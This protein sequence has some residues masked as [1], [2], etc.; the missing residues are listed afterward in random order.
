ML[1]IPNP[2]SDLTEVVKI[3]CDIFPIL[4]TYK[5][6]D[7]D[8]VSTA[9]IKTSNVTSQGAIGIE[10][11]QR[12]TRADRSRDPIYNQ[13]KALCELYRLLGWLQSTTAQTKFIVTY[14]GEALVN[15]ENK[16]QIVEE[17][18]LGLTYPNECVEVK[19]DASLRPFKSILY[20]LNENSSITRDEIIYGVLNI[21]D[22]SDIKILNKLAKEMQTFR[23]TK[24]GLKNR[25]IEIG[26][27]LSIK[28]D[29]TM[30]NYTRFPI[31]A[32]KWAD[33]VEKKS[34]RLAATQG[35]LS[36]YKNLLSYQDLRLGDF[37]ALPPK[38]K[39]DLIIYSHLNMMERF[40]INNNSEQ[41]KQSFTRLRQNGI[42]KTNNI[43]F[44]PYQILS[45]DT[46]K[47]YAPD[48][49][50]K[51]ATKH[52]E[53]NLVDSKSISAVKEEIKLNF[54][55]DS[56]NRD[57]SYIKNLAIYK[58]ID[59]LLKQ[60]K[61][62]KQTIK[63]LYEKYS[64]VNKEI[65]YPL[66]ADLFCIIGFNC[67]VSRGGQNYERADAIIIDDK[68]SIPI[69][70][71][72]PGEETEISVKAV[73]QALEN[74]IIFL[75]RQQYKTD[76]ST[77]SLAVGYNL[78]NSRSEVF[79]LID[80]IYKTFKFNICILGFEDLLVLAISVITSGKEIKIENFRTL[81]GVYNVR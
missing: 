70:I 28:Y 51:D 31:A 37:N 17:C 81:R 62:E 23:K 24:D 25:L 57:V 60:T 36:F 53:T 78:P 68:Y 54:S 1:R 65:Y 14:L 9:L 77:T 64:T 6:F 66:I 19:S 26:N 11:L 47:K 46:L 42:I 44:S 3:Y 16:N 75:S 22:D 59:S 73:R 74:K 67:K 27:E 45:F 39:S 4:K 2:I 13:S 49:I 32:I 8:T 29:P 48:L 38:A 33:F 40:G 76:E 15:S 30:G 80:D 41:M 56:K 50:F 63:K 18:L 71:K 21:D 79:E 61:S 7:L 20:Y 43:L 72:S 35:A 55:I 12:S 34:A 58:E 69:E 10:A 52:I 5:D